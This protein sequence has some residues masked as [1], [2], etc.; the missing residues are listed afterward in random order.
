MWPAIIIIAFSVLAVYVAGCWWKTD[1]EGTDDEIIVKHWGEN[2]KYERRYVPMYKNKWGKT[3]YGEFRSDYN[4][5]WQHV[6]YRRAFGDDDV[7]TKRQ[8]YHH[9]LY[10]DDWIGRQ[11]AKREKRSH[12][13]KQQAGMTENS[14]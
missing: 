14:A 2:N 11:I 6:K 3:Y 5:G 12:K 9:Y 13:A 8:I 10:N 4:G 1:Y 7:F